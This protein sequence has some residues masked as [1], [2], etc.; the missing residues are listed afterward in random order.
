MATHD[1]APLLG[2]DKG[3]YRVWIVGNSGVC[4]VANIGIHALFVIDPCAIQAP[5]RQVIMIW[6]TG[7]LFPC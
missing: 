2:D 1:L 7:R 6:S 4:R 3:R 5:E